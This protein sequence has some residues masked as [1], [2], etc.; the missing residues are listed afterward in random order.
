MRTHSTH[1]LIF[2]GKFFV[3][4][5]VDWQATGREKLF[6]NYNAFLFFCVAIYSKTLK[7]YFLFF[8]KYDEHAEKGTT[9]D[10]VHQ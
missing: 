3:C 7:L 2:G 10:V 5:E 8:A 6:T 4:P 1:A 9:N